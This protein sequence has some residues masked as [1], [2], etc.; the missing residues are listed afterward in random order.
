MKTELVAVV[1]L[2]VTVPTLVG[3]A[4][5]YE[6]VGP[7]RARLE[8][9]AGEAAATCIR[10]RAYSEWARG[11]CYDECVQAF[12]THWDDT[13]KRA[14]WQNEYWGKTMLCYA[15]AVAYTHDAGLKAWVLEKTHAFLKEFQWANGYLSTY[16]R[17]DFLRAN[18]ENPDAKKHWCFNIWGQKYTLWALVDIA[19]LT[20]DKAAL[21]GAVKLA[22]HMI[23]Q[24]NRMG[25][26]IDRTG[27]WHG[28]SSMSILRPMLE[29][30]RLTGNPSYK[31][32]ADGIVRAM[33]AEPATPATL[34]RNAF[35]KEK[36]S[37]WFPEPGFWAKAYEIQSCLEGLVDYYRLTG[38]QRVLDGVLAFYGHLEREELNA[39][40]SAGHFDHFWGGAEQFNGL[41]ELCDVTHWIRL[42]RE[43]LLVTGGAKYADRIEEAFLNAFLAGVTRDGRW[44]AHIVRSHGTRHLWAPPQ[45]G[46]FHHQCCPD[47]MM[48]TYFDVAQSIAVSAADGTVAV[49][50]YTDGT[51]RLPEAEVTVAGGY[52]WADEPVV[53]CVRREKAGRVRLRVPEW[54]KTFSVNGVAASA[55]DG[56]YETEAPAGESSW[57]LAFDLSPRVLEAKVRRNAQ[58]P[59]SPSPSS[60]TDV[61]AYTR[62]F[63]EWA[64]PEMVGLARWEA[65]VR[66]MRGP[67]VLAKGRLAGT[68]RGRTFAT[69][70]CENGTQGWR[71]TLVPRAVSA[72]T[73]AV[74][75]VWDLTLSRGAET[76][77]MPVS[78]YASLSNFDDPDNW[79]SLWF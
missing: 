31:A 9:R 30:Y 54:S 46:M 68:P 53:V 72:E 18:P 75:R 78:D 52:P 70:S 45:T 67:L 57:S 19:R 65:A 22:D 48:R 21:D 51:V 23:A 33:D 16:A 13:D 24:L 6:S 69:V 60:I 3:A 5:S 47:N 64:T 36:I 40:R 55:K 37:S 35:R 39:M 43:L 27:S 42:N 15:G 25:L 73:A 79:F 2:A 4:V 32:L 62:R 26:T 12:R 8:G 58:L 61:G 77:T 74:P 14:G 38:S 44:G 29:L 66:V 17:E 59:A 76:V 49:A 34:I 20:G 7:D 28:I 71:A 10:A 50:L 41:T 63:M 56:W 11:A 1:S